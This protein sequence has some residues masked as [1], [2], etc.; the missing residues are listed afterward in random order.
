MLPDT[1]TDT[2]QLFITLRPRSEELEWTQVDLNGLQVD[3]EGM[4]NWNDLQ[5]ASVN[6]PIREALEPFDGE[7]VCRMSLCL[8]VRAFDVMPDDESDAFLTVWN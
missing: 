6:F 4:D 2:S 1:R 8:G 3:F 5:W 7:D